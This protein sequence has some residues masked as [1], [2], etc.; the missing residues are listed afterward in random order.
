M[1]NYK[2]LTFIFIL[3]SFLLVIT[4]TTVE[5][6]VRKS[7]LSLANIVVEE[8]TDVG[9]T[10]PASFLDSME[11]GRVAFAN[12]LDTQGNNAIF[13][14]KEKTGVLSIIFS[15]LS[16]LAQFLEFICSYVITFYPMLIL[17]LYFFLTS[18][19]FRRNDPY[20]Y[21]DYNY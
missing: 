14:S 6:Q 17:L 19:L 12:F 20:G 8:S 1:F 5:K 18:R 7:L 15:F 16:Y 21:G 2:R 9:N 10:A 11:T 4:D 3:I 13:K